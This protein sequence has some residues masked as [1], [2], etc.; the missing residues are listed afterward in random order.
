MLHACFTSSLPAPSRRGAPLVEQRLLPVRQGSLPIRLHAHAL[1]LRDS[2]SCTLRS[3]R[4]GAARPVLALKGL[5]EGGHLWVGE[6]LVGHE[7]EQP[8]RLE[9]H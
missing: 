4:T 5:V 2:S 3:G 6:D 1:L 8:R 7:G 9:R